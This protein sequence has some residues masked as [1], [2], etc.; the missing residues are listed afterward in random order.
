MNP[1]LKQ[2]LVGATVL[3]I[4]G[5]IILPMILDKPA[6]LTSEPEVTNI[7][8]T[9][10][11]ERQTARTEQAVQKEP[12]TIPP[13]VIA[14]YEDSEKPQ[15]QQAPESVPEK[16]K[17]TTTKKP[18]NKEEPAVTKGNSQWAVQVISL[19]SKENANRLV[20]RFKSQNLPAYFENIESSKGKTIYRVRVGPFNSKQKTEKLKQKLDQEENL[21][22]LIVTLH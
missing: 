12:K 15:K 4:L 5:I 10:Y 6:S 7:E 16:V 11:K 3:V 13:E 9:P 22:T 2:R 17:P 19:S 20:E 14:R 18:E 1:H 21:K 8:L